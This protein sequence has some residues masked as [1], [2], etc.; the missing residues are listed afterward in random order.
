M[1]TT[2]IRAANESGHQGSNIMSNGKLTL[3][4]LKAEVKAG[5]IDTVVV[6]FTD[7]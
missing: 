1:G 6:A 5:T 4:E 3:D 7:M 2:P